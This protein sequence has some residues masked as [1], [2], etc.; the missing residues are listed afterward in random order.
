MGPRIFTVRQAN[1]LIP[2]LESAFAE[3]DRVRDRLRKVKSKMDVLEMLWAEEVHTE[4]C[5][6]SREYKHYVEEIESARHAYEAATRKL[7][8]HE[9]VLKSVEAGL[10]DFY[11]VIEGR[12]VF[13]CWKRG[14]TAVDFFHHLEDGFPGRQQI[15]PEYKLR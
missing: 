2:A 15:A 6:D 13:L 1:A 11:G 4:S 5:P 9:V 3:L 10:I 8:D 12:L 7:V 14:E